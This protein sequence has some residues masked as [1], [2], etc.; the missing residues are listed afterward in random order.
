MIDKFEITAIDIAL[1][2]IELFYSKQSHV[3]SENRKEYGTFS[4]SLIN[5]KQDQTNY[6]FTLGETPLT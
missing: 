2:Y 6:Y 1:S 3:S 4:N 5:E